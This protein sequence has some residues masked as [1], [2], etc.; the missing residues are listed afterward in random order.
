IAQRR[1]LES[2]L[3]PRAEEGVARR[4][5]ETADRNLIEQG[6]RFTAQ[7]LALQAEELRRDVTTDPDPASDRHAWRGQRYQAGIPAADLQKLS[8]S[9]R[10]DLV[11]ARIAE[12]LARD[13]ALSAA[14]P[15]APA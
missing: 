12:D 7:Q 11:R 6:Q 10:E 4:F 14:P 13:R 15:E 2:K 5:I 9:Q 8:E 1:A 3:L